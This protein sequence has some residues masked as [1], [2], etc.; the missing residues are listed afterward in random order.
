MFLKFFILLLFLFILFLCFFILSK[1]KLPLYEHF[2]PKTLSSG[3]Y[4]INTVSTKVICIEVNGINGL[5]ISMKDSIEKTNYNSFLKFNLN[6]GDDIVDIQCAN[7]NYWY[8]NYSSKYGTEES[9]TIVG[10]N[11][12]A[13]GEFI[14][15]SSISSSQIFQNALLFENG[16][17]ITFDITGTHMI[18]STIPS[19]SFQSAQC[20]FALGSYD[21]DNLLGN[22]MVLLNSSLDPPSNYFFYNG[23]CGINNY[24]GNKKNGINPFETL[25]IYVPNNKTQSILPFSNGCFI[26]GSISSFPTGEK[27][28]RFVGSNA[29]INLNLNNTY[30]LFQIWNPSLSNYFYYNYSNE[31]GLIDTKFSLYSSGNSYWNMYSLNLLP[32]TPSLPFKD[33]GFSYIDQILIYNP[34]SSNKLAV[35]IQVDTNTYF[36]KMVV[37][38]GANNYSIT[39]SSV[40]YENGTISGNSNAISRF[41]FNL[42]SLSS[43]IIDFNFGEL[44]LTTNNDNKFL[45]NE[46]GKNQL[47]SLVPNIS[48]PAIRNK[49][50]NL[51]IFENVINFEGGTQIGIDSSGNCI[52]KG[53]TAQI[54]YNIAE[55]HGGFTFCMYGINSNGTWNESMNNIAI[56]INKKGIFMISDKF[57][58]STLV[59]KNTISNIINDVSNIKL[60]SNIRFSNDIQF[61][62]KEETL[63][64]MGIS[65]FFLSYLNAGNGNMI[66]TEKKN[67]KTLS[68]PYFISS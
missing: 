45:L 58:P 49:P 56:D 34:D 36:N 22:T 51:L 39:I 18:I 47:F 31:V 17:I 19:N 35:L 27:S 21:Y 30:D 63:N 68:F 4:I 13:V 29:V 62:V 41:F 57:N 26:D 50:P 44:Y 61:I 28:L 3:F 52:W 10:D 43:N 6:T 66:E 12:E 2:T 40:F 24:G 37:P 59:S 38:E 64:L 55:L 23:S 46:K 20:I 11:N 65:G 60:I 25:A 42:N 14:D 5:K 7:G 33:I 1:K 9:C 67:V 8:F 48:T 32:Y 54:E 53:S 15:L 16:T